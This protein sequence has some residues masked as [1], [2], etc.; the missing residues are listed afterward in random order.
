[1]KEGV[2]I[3]CGDILK[4]YVIVENN[5]IKEI[6]YK[7]QAS[8]ITKE[9]ADF[10]INKL[11]GLNIEEIKNFPFEKYVKEKG[12]KMPAKKKK[13]LLF[14]EAIFDALGLEDF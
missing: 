9:F 11:I 6:T 7:A 1:M 14:K 4:V 13:A 3:E 8:Q 5:T 10:F 2:G 12:I